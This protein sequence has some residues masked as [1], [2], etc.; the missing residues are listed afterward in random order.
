MDINAIPTDLI[1][2]VDVLTG[3]ASAI[4]GADGVTGVVNFILK[5]DLD[6]V[7]ARAQMGVTKYG[8]GANRFVSIIAGRNFADDR[9]NITLAY[10]YSAEDRVRYDQRPFLL[11]NR[12]VY[13]IPNDVDV[14]DS[15]SVPDQILQGDLR[16][17]DISPFGAV[18]VGGEAAPSFNG[19]GQPYD[20]GQGA[21]YYRTGGRDNSEVAGYYQ[22]DQLPDID[23]NAVNLLGHYDFSDAFKLSVEGKFAQTSATSYG[24]YTET[25]YQPI[26]LDNAFV[27][28]AI[29]GAAASQGA[30]GLFVNRSNFDYPRRG[31]N[32]RRR[33]YRGVVDLSGR[34]SDHL[35][36]D[37]YYE[38]GRT[39]V[40]INTRND[41]LALQ[42]SNAID[43][44]VNPA[45]GAIVCRSTLTNP[46]GGCVPISIF[47]PGPATQQ[48]LNYFLASDVSRARVTQ[49][50]ANASLSGDFGRFFELPGGPVQFSFG[51]EYRRETSRFDPN[52]N[53]LNARYFQYDEPTV[54]RPS[55]GRF[56]VKEAFGELN[57]PL[58]KDAPFAEL[59][60][61]GAAGRYSD[62]STVGSTKTWQFN[63]VYAPVRDLT[64]RGSYGEAVRAPNITELF[65]PTTSS[66]N[67]FTDPCTPDQIN[68]GT[69]F[70][71]ANCVASLAAVGA[72]VSPTLQ[73]GAFVNGT[74]SGNLDLDPETAR[75]WTA[76]VVLRPRFLPGFTAS[77]DWYDIKL[78]RAINQV[79]PSD[80]ANLCVD[81]PTLDNP[82]CGAIRRATAA[83]VAAAQLPIATGTIFSY[84]VNPQNVASF[85]TAGLDVNLDY[86]IRTANAGT[87][88]LRLVGGYLHRLEFIGI[89]G[90]PVTDRRDFPGSPKWTAN[91]S[92]SWTLGGLTL[93]YNLR[94]NNATRVFD[95]PTVAAN[96][97]IVER[98][99]LRFSELWQHDVQIRYQ[100]PDGFALYGGVTNLT[101]QKPDAYS[102][103]TN[104]PISPLG[105]F[106]YVGARINLGR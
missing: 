4:Y 80:L 106:L 23:R 85:R 13:L 46:N 66:S 58:F 1:E 27:P 12:R 78:K 83:D 41:R 20:R 89:I 86:L 79:T 29:R 91:F 68:N 47:G 104:V 99:Y 65:Q 21:A 28:A 61:F 18:F 76:G 43:A 62:Y 101:D 54:V 52:D 30:E 50:V 3:S 102:F 105:R 64:F 22:G 84:A 70:R 35:S 77:F 100:L 73:S 5:R 69:E 24:Q 11:Q 45:T 8:D 39:D 42:Y 90:A 14:G 31:E 55:R 53:L 88:D 74:A 49:K 96:P 44:V 67:F 48:Q 57:A 98:R 72:V 59:L 38:Y 34:L 40:R 71:Q 7:R 2:R 26:A 82:F 92:P 81:Q 32:D 63:G 15:P 10:E 16:Y 75:T 19:S 9:G 94:W 60:S 87:F 93:N 25:Y 56:N 97:D 103:G 33:T 51:A 6:G 36:W 95:R 37:A 17:T